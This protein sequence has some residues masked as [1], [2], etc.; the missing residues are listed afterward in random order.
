[1][2]R[3][4]ILRYVWAGASLIAVIAGLVALRSTLNQTSIALALV[5]VVSTVAAI[6]GRGPAL[7]IA[8]FAGLA[9]NFFFLEPYHSFTIRQP[10]DVMAF[11]AFVTTAILV[12]RLAT[13]LQ[14][15]TELAK[16]QEAALDRQAAEAEI[17]R[18]GEQLKSAL[19]DAVTHDLRTPLT[20]IKAAATTLRNS[21]VSPEAQIELCE[22]IE[23]ETDRLNHF[24]EGM[25][26]LAQLRAGS[27][28]LHSRAAAAEEIIENA[29]VRAD[30]L[31][32][33]RE[34][35][36]NAD[37]ELAL[38]A[39]PRLI[40]EVLFTLIENANRYAP[41]DT[42]ITIAA[43]RRDSNV[44]FSVTDQGGGIP[45]SDRERIFQ[46]FQRGDSSTGM[47]L[48][49]AIARGIVEA[50]GGRIWTEPGA[51]GRGTSFRFT[52]PNRSVS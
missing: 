17:L 52:I 42:P 29:I 8:A 34:V 41:N 4:G 27:L 2:E 14:R 3:Q 36:I 12:G 19:L 33:E 15:R 22:V 28:Q 39:D 32:R 10:Q 38:H 7:V 31:L 49:L 51:E 5:L 13:R 18:R 1:M 50:H 21:P 37:P 6:A 24:V 9:F 43:D 30:P 48:G 20:S 25:M 26:E 47:G 44:A 35:V 46:H 45:A 40:A 16:Q 11:V 23:Q